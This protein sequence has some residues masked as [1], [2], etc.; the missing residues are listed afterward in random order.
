MSEASKQKSV[1]S[2]IFCE[3]FRTPAPA[4]VLFLGER[5]AA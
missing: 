1:E 5:D 4:G 3:I 2:A